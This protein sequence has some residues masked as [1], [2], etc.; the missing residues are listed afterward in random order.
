MFKP[1]EETRLSH[2]RVLGLIPGQFAHYKLIVKYLSYANLA[3]C[4]KKN[5]LL[6]RYTHKPS[7]LTSRHLSQRSL[8][9]L[10]N[11]HHS[12]IYSQE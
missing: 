5:Q 2:I 8:Q 10:N 6:S 9:K 3:I 7:N 12:L 11:V 1:A 4:T